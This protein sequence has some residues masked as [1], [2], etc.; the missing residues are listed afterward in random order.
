MEMCESKDISLVSCPSISTA[1]S[2]PTTTTMDTH[3]VHTTIP[4]VIQ[5]TV[6]FLGLE[7]SPDDAKVALYV[8]FV[9]LIVSALGVICFVYQ[10]LKARRKLK[11]VA[12]ESFKMERM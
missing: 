7:L 6:D 8:I 12:E 4:V 2:T 1:T 10:L 9:F 3:T 11:K 5:S